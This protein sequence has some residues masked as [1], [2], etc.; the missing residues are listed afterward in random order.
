MKQTFKK[1]AAEVGFVLIP[2]IVLGGIVFY[3]GWAEPFFESLNPH[4]RILLD[5]ILSVSLFFSLGS[6][7]VL[8]LNYRRLFREIK[9]RKQAEEEVR[10]LRHANKARAAEIL[11]ALDENEFQVY[12]Q[13]IVELRDGRIVGF[14]A[15][16]RWHHPTH[17]ILSPASFMPFIEE[18][19]LIVSLTKFMLRGVAR[20]ISDWRYAFPEASLPTISINLSWQHGLYSDAVKDVQE[21]LAKFDDFVPR[22]LCFELTETTAAQNI[23]QAVELT[24]QFQ[25]LGISVSIDDFG[26]GYSSLSY[27]GDIPATSVKI[28]RSFIKRMLEQTRSDIV[29]RSIIKMAHELKLKVVAEGIETDEQMQHLLNLG[30]EFGQGYLFAR[31]VQAKDA[32]RMLA[33]Q[34]SGATAEVHPNGVL[35]YVTKAAWDQL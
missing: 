3:S 2:C 31:P 25:R 28:D 29:V 14:E 23:E 12:Y 13:P 1:S 33:S 11:L 17:G 18:S 10:V 6:M 7:I 30:C 15:L 8:G 32:Y 24:K 26:T 22:H 27:L 5:K 21:I 16:V 20:Q 34:I 9:L 4:R 35:K 19:E